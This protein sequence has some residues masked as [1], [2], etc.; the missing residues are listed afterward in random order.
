MT[1]PNFPIFSPSDTEKYFQCPR[2]RRLEKEWAPRA[3]VW[4]PWRDLGLAIHAGLATHWNDPAEFPERIALET[5]SDCLIGVD[6]GE[7]TQ[8]S[9]DALTE[10]GLAKGLATDLIGDG[11]V[12]GAELRPAGYHAVLDLLHETLSEDL[13]ITD[14]KVKKS[15]PKQLSYVTDEYDPA[16]QTWHYAWVVWREYHKVPT[17]QYHLIFLQPSP[18]A[19]LFTPTTQPTEQGLAIWE[20][21]ARR[22]WLDMARDS[23]LGNMTLPAPNTR[24]CHAYGRQCDFYQFCWSGLN[25][26]TQDIDMLYQRREQP[27]V[28][29][30]ID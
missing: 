7:W 22:V 29:V 26:R 6:T 28:D 30:V 25:G 1:A 13:V 21:N 19:Y 27:M 8:E 11:R 14:H 9:L 16:W 24:S 10:K 20:S 23:G 18:R 2:L 3:S 5:L 15:Y 17:I 4:T 12:I